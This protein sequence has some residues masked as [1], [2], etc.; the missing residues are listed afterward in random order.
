MFVVLPQRGPDDLMCC[1]DV[2]YP[3]VTCY[4]VTSCRDVTNEVRRVDH[5]DDADHSTCPETII[6]IKL[7][8]KEAENL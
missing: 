3:D 6:K 8:E 2:M 1:A 4:D 5:V 7:T